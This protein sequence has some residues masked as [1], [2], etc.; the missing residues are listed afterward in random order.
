VPFT[1]LKARE[2]LAMQYILRLLLLGI[3]M[4]APTLRVVEANETH[5]GKDK[6]IQEKPFPGAWNDGSSKAKFEYQGSDYRVYEPTR[7]AGPGKDGRQVA[8]ITTRIDHIRG[9]IVDGGAKDDYVLI[10]LQFDDETARL[11]SLKVETFIAG[12]NKLDV[13]LITEIAS[14]KGEK[15]KV[16]AE[17]VAKSLNS[18][19]D[20][21]QKNAERGGRA[22]LPGLVTHTI[23][24]MLKHAH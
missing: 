12:T 4:A 22:Q 19:N 6:F 8:T 20:W 2:E 7:S 13:G 24:I 5:L 11:L 15:E 23:N 16:I 21:L 14:K 3:V 10:T 1:Y 17:V 9:F 18:L